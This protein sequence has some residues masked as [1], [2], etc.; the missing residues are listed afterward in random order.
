MAR[1]GAAWEVVRQAHNE[2]LNL[3]CSMV[4][5]RLL[6]PND[7]GVAVAAGFFQG[8]ASR[9]T[10]FGFN[11]ALVRLRDLRNEHSA[12]VF[13]VNVTVGTVIAG[14]FLVAGPAMGRFFDS[15]D[16]GRVLPV[17]GLGFLIGAFGTVPNA[18]LARNMMFRQQTY[19]DW[20]TTWSYVL[21]VISLAWFGWGYWAIVLGQLFSGVVQVTTNMVL[22]P[23]KPSLAFSRAAMKDVFSFGMGMYAK[24]LLDYLGGQLDN[25]IVGRSLG[26]TSLG[27]YD[28]AFSMMGRVVNRAT[29][30]SGTSFRIY[31][32]IQDDAPRFRRGYQLTMTSVALVGLPGFAVAAA[33]APELID[34]LFGAQWAASVVPFQILALAGAMRVLNAYNSSAL[35]AFGQ[36]WREA[37]RSLCYVVV[38]VGLVAVGSWWGLVG[39]SWGVVGATVIST[40]LSWGLM[41]RS[42]PL[43]W[44]DVTAPLVPGLL[45][46]AVTGGATLGLRVALANAGVQSSLVELAVQVAGA[47]LAYAVF[48]FLAPFATVRQIASDA[49]AQFAPRWLA[50][51]DGQ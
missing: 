3:A 12:S 20:A 35:Q 10:G 13:A 23:W 32:I 46:A 17:A 48:L 41:C 8:L 45:A 5:A 1:A 39:A 15:V 47:A 26:L 50:P 14:L 19:V 43:G 29:I 51:K 37:W 16:A 28:K 33:A 38:L 25:V 4:M 34:V 42:T 7:F 49:W 11:A 30:G 24:R 9:M 6:T 22:S 18:I 36:V 31:A 44:R 27:Y 40:A 21:A 2:V